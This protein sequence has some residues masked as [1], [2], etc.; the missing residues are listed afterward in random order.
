MRLSR[1]DADDPTK[2]RHF[3]IS[4]DSPFHILSCRATQANIELPAY[5]TPRN[6]GT[7]HPHL[8]ECG[9]PGAAKRRLS[10]AQ[11]PSPDNGL[12]PPLQPDGRLRAASEGTASGLRT[13]N[14]GSAPQRLPLD[15]N[16]ISNTTPNN[17]NGLQI[18]T[19]IA[20]PAAAHT[21]SNTPRIQRPMHMVRAPSF[22]PPAFEAEEPPPPLVTPPPQYNDIASPTNGLADY[23]SR[24]AEVYDD[25]GADA[26]DDGSPGHSEEGGG[27]ATR[28]TGRVTVPL[29]PGGSVSRSMELRRDW[30]PMGR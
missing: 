24:L 17:T 2:R 26:D 10:P 15:A 30:L 7:Q 6:S 8:S 9:C 22:N 19:D 5:S 27:N 12:Y 28:R 29:T 14:R 1:P 25:L 16:G 4:I 3:E 11:M 13:T 20:F 18:N 21:H 23:F